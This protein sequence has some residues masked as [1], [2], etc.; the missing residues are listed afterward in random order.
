[1]ARQS[2]G[3]LQAYGGKWHL[4]CRPPYEEQ[5]ARIS[6]L[7]N[8]IAERPDTF[9]QTVLGQLQKP[10]ADGAGHTFSACR[11]AVRFDVRGIVICVSADR[12][13]PASSRNRF[14]QMPRRAQRTKRLSW[15]ADRTR[16]G[17]RTRDNR[18]SAHGQCR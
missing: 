12:P 10:L 4:R 15:L 14:S 8:G 17:N 9:V 13:H 18:L 6:I 16:A 2:I 11:R 7:V 5:N 1:M 3:V